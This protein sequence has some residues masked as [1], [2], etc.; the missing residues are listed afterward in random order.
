MKYASGESKALIGFR[1]PLDG[2]DIF[3]A[4]T[5]NFGKEN[6]L[7]KE[8]PKGRTRFGYKNGLIIGS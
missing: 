8:D 2:L 4:K 6:H 5:R 3:H 1:T 7:H